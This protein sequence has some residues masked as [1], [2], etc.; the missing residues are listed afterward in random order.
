MTTYLLIQSC[1][2]T[3]RLLLEAIIGQ[4][5]PGIV[6][7]F[8]FPGLGIGEIHPRLRG[9]S[10]ETQLFHH[11]AEIF[12]PLGVEFF[13]VSSGRVPAAKSMVTYLHLPQPVLPFTAISVEG[14]AFFSRETFVILGNVVWNVKAE[15]GIDEHVAIVKSLIAREIAKS[16]VRPTA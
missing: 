6:V 4:Q 13:G 1:K 11:A 5:L 7:I 12:S 8:A 9:C 15:S 16:I 2:A 10:H 3:D 14:D